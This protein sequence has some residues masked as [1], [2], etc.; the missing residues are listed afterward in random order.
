MELPLVSVNAALMLTSFAAQ[1]MML[2]SVVVMAAFWFTLRPAANKTLPLVVVMGAFTLMSRPQHTEKF[3]STAVTAACMLVSRSASKVR[4]VGA[5]LAVQLTA[6][7]TKISPLPGPVAVVM[8]TLLVTSWA[9]SV[10]PE[11]LPPAPM[12]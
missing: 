4:V 1:I 2:P 8:V 3:P 11:M 5:P 12:M 9:E 6:S 7:L 10:A